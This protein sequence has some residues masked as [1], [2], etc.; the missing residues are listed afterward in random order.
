[1]D[2]ACKEHPVNK[3]VLD[4]ILECIALKVKFTTKKEKEN[5]H[6]LKLPW[7]IFKYILEWG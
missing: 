6:E 1:V 2:V 3:L 5:P 7:S 4:S